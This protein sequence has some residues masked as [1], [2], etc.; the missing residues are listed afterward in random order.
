[1][2]RTYSSLV[3]LVRNWA[4]RDSEVLTDAIID[5]CLKYAADKA[6]RYL[7]ILPLE[8]TVV[9]D[10]N[11]LIAA[12]T[13]ATLSNSGRTELAAPTDLIEFIQIR[14][15]DANNN[16]TRVFNEK[17]DLRT[18][19][20]V[21][22]VVTGDHWSRQGNTILL[23]PGFQQGGV[24]SP[25]SIEL[26]YYKRLTALNATYNVTATNYTAGLLNASTQ[27]TAGSAPL[28]LVT[29]A[30]VT[31]AYDTLAAAQAVGTAQTAYFVGKE[32]ANWLR[33]ENE[34]IVL[35]GALAEVFAFLQE[36]EQTQKYAQMFMQEIDEL[37]NEDKKRNARGGN[38]QIN[39]SG[40]G[41][42]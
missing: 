39:F 23:S 22:A 1:M 5:D 34:K 27:G 21:N 32:A 11:A 15:V 4:N 17:L 40:G 37:N 10:T 25:V 7:R 20:D 2:A 6:Y 30:G 13:A 12:T 41:L 31:T 38:I 36:D 14:E 33:D 3:S 9:Y 35:M 24:G 16:T 42:I 28:Y 26:H 8:A 29:L 18:Y 19:N